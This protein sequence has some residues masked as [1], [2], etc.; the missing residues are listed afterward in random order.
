[1]KRRAG[2]IL[3]TATAVFGPG[4]PAVA[5]VP[6]STAAAPQCE[7]TRRGGYCQA[8][9]PG[10]YRWQVPDGVTRITVDLHGAQGGGD[11]G[12][13]GGLV[14]AVLP[15]TPRQVLWFTVGGRGCD[16]DDC[17]GTSAGYNGGGAAGGAYERGGGGAGGGGATD[18]RTGTGGLD[19]RVLV[20]GGGGGAGGATG[21]TRLNV[22][23]FTPFLDVP[24]ATVSA[25]GR[26]GGL[27]GEATTGRPVPIGGP[28]GTG[29]AG[30]AGYATPAAQGPVT[31]AADTRAGSFGRGGAGDSDFFG[32]TS[33]GGGGGGWFGGAGGGRPI[34]LGPSG[35]GGGGSAYVHPAARALTLAV[36]D[37][38]GDGR[39]LFSWRVAR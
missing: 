5:A 28:H 11:L 18:V 31:P 16:V 25:G 21:S 2:S 37:N 23:G 6:L 12:G 24:D 9:R 27:D 26:G 1:M 36:G 33:G 13:G 29:T 3:L 10:R 7:Q 20:A 38:R 34:Y 22:L 30:G 15:V 4:T 17:R 19:E 14:R 35:G 39:V 32:S 8:H